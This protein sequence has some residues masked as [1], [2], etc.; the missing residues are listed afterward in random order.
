VSDYEPNASQAITTGQA[1]VTQLRN[2]VAERLVIRLDDIVRGAEVADILLKDGD[3][4]FVPDRR[5]EVTVIGEVQYATSHVYERGLTRDE[6]LAKSGGT[7]QRADTKRTYVVRANGELVTQPGGRWFWRDSNSG[8][9]PGRRDR[10]AAQ[11]RS[12]ACAV[13]CDYDDYLQHGAGGGG[14]AFV[15][16]E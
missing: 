12:A 5:Q 14:C 6:Y 9:K 3:E 1:L 10:R 8:I 11:G 7:T 16:S 2:S 13:E 4:L 15:L